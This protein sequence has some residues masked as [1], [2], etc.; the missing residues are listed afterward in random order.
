MP[1]VKCFAEFLGISGFFPLA[2]NFGFRQLYY[3]TLQFYRVNPKVI[4]PN[5][6][7]FTR[8]L[9]SNQI[10]RDLGFIS[11][12]LC[13]LFCLWFV[14]SVNILLIL[15]FSID[16]IPRRKFRQC[17]LLLLHMLSMGYL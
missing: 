10:S 8:L 11:R 5:T 15:V 16:I 17:R 2:L 7:H 13:I 9:T 1:I 12:D 6:V 14:I 4:S 3:S